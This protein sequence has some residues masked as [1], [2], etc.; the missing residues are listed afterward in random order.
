ME[1][2]AKFLSGNSTANWLTVVEHFNCTTA[3]S[4]TQCMRSV[5]ALDIK[6]FIETEVLNF[7]PVY[8]NVTAT[9]DVR[10]F[11]L[12]KEFAQ[13][14]ILL[15]TNAQEGRSVAP[16][17][18]LAVPNLTDKEYLNLTYP[19][20][21]ALQSSILRAYPPYE[22]SQPYGLPALVLTDGFFMCPASILANT[23]NANGHNIWR[24]YYN[25]SFPNT[26]SFPDAGVYH[27]SE[28]PEIWGTYPRA[29]ATLEETQL[30]NYMQKTWADFAK[31][32]VKGPGWA[33]L[34]TNGGK[35]L[36]VI[37]GHNRTIKTVPLNTTDFIC[38]VY[39]GYLD[40]IGV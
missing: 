30:S 24:Y 21:P 37:G 3:K 5:N 20:R 17:T 22:A 11:I 10:P 15:G 27:Y 1:S 25:A 2:E 32:P 23:A 6:R 31:D 40:E 33:R 9:T 35:E 14:P 13:V 19:N 7:S 26:Q 4:P 36:G 29:N 8:N 18:E 28:I 39:A 34:G 12:S 16:Q 38:N